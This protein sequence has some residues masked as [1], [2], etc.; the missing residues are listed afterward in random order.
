MQVQVYENKLTRE[1]YPLPPQRNRDPEID[2]NV[3]LIHVGNSVVL[4]IR[5][6]FSEI[7]DVLEW[8]RK[9]GFAK[10]KEADYVLTGAPAPE[11]TRRLLWL[12][13]SEDAEATKFN[14]TSNFVILPDSF[15]GE[16]FLIECAFETKNCGNWVVYSISRAE[17]HALARP[18]DRLALAHVDDDCNLTVIG[19]DTLPRGYTRMKWDLDTVT[20][21]NPAVGSWN[22]VRSQDVAFCATDSNIY[23][24]DLPKMDVH[25]LT[26]GNVVVVGPGAFDALDL[27]AFAGIG[28]DKYDADL[29]A[30]GHGK[31]F[32][33]DANYSKWFDVRVEGCDWIK[34][35][36]MY[37]TDEDELQMFALTEATEDHPIRSMIFTEVYVREDERDPFNQLPISEEDV[38]LMHDVTI[39][40]GSQDFKVMA[41][42]FCSVSGS[43]VLKK[44]LFGDFKESIR[45][46]KRARVDRVVDLTELV[47][48]EPECF[49]QIYR[50]VMHGR[51]SVAYYLRSIP[52]AAKA[53]R[54]A[55]ALDMRWVLDDLDTKLDERHVDRGNVLE[56]MKALDVKYV[57][58]WLKCKCVKAFL[59]LCYKDRNRRAVWDKLRES[60]ADWAV[61][62]MKFTRVVA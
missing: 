15:S 22:Q 56:V 54:M 38:E 36:Q 41:S 27:N 17:I 46:S 43:E 37:I 19:S 51:Y 34:A 55:H 49:D 61:E 58:P 26:N 13:Q 52:E 31:L 33:F 10:V 53:Y 7:D 21:T 60:S 39:R 8:T 12:R 20:T 59:N 28:A 1:E 9:D 23:R 25:N 4:C 35:E 50:V 3:N 29:Y 62:C 42:T 6:D 32:R 24:I 48:D 18:S 14:G 30:S 40:V 16:G 47:G 45:D 2:I 5:S 57:S 44:M 11:V